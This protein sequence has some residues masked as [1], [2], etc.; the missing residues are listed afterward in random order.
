M[1]SENVP[2]PH[3]RRT[4]WL[5]VLLVL[6]SVAIALLPVVLHMPAP[7]SR[8]MGIIFVYLPA[9]LAVAACYFFDH[10]FSKK[11]KIEALFL[12]V[13]FAFL[14]NYL[15]VW[16]VDLGRYF[17]EVP[18]LDWQIFMQNSVINLSPRDAAP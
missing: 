1:R 2:D 4:N 9:M 15:H 17:K 5:V 7:S 18:N 14:T 8:R 16:L 10:T 3:L 11:E 13:A 6:L 12:C